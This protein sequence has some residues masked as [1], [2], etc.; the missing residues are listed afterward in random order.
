MKKFVPAETKDPKWQ[1]L[2]S[3]TKFKEFLSKIPTQPI[4]GPLSSLKQ[5]AVGVIMWTD[6]WDTST[7]C[8]S[9]RSPM[10]TG[11]ITLL[12]VDVASQDIVGIVT[13]PNMG[14]PG[15]I[16]HGPVFRRFQ[17]DIVEYENENTNRV[18]SSR[19]HSCKVQ[20][21]AKLLFIVQDQPVK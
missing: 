5:L 8:K 1:S 20:C 14:G 10:H 6:G 15:K 2:T 3:S 13:Y 16:D 17:E 9:N 12:F 11:T 4:V 18:F 21:Y 19:Y 7:G